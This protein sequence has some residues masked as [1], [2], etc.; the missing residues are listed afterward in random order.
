METVINFNEIDFSFFEKLKK[1]FGD[2]MVR[3]T[4]EE[5][6]PK[7]SQKEIFKKLEALQKKYPP[8]II[9]KDINLSDLANEVNL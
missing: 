6:P 5:T 2:K 8:K 1:Q 4:I 7:V 9:S 3:I